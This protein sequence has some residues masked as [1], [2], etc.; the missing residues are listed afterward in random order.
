MSLKAKKQTAAGYSRHVLT[1]KNQSCHVPWPR[2]PTLHRFTNLLLEARPN[3]RGSF[4]PALY[5]Y[6]G[7]KSSLKLHTITV[8]T[9]PNF[10]LYFRK[11]SRE[12][13]L[14]YLPRFAVW[15]ADVSWMPRDV[16]IWRHMITFLRQRNLRPYVAV[17]RGTVDTKTVTSAGHQRFDWCVSLPQYLFIHIRT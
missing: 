2:L 4:V 12:S 9:Y 16:E 3:P 15:L 13:G 8:R 10:D 6:H 11:P 14:K 17:A 1:N 5:H 7:Q